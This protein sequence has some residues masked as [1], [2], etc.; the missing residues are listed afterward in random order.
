[1]LGTAIKPE[2]PLLYAQRNKF[3]LPIGCL[4]EEVHGVLDQEAAAVLG[5]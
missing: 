3:K 4:S 1:M 2:Q 5:V